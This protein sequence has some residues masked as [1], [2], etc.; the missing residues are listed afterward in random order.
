MSVLF[1][2][3]TGEKLAVESALIS[4]Q[5]ARGP[6]ELA[7]EVKDLI[8]EALAERDRDEALL[9]RVLERVRGTDQNKINEAYRFLQDYCR[10][11]I[12]IHALIRGLIQQAQ[13]AGQVISRAAALDQATHDYE[14]WQDDYAELLV[15][16]YEPVGQL[17][18]DRV[19]HA[20]RRASKES[21]WRQLFADE[22]SAP[23]TEQP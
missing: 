3:R 21:N 23:A 15:M 5:A 16:A 8:E 4:W 19:A 13:Q 14:A 9:Q 18:R 1:Q 11:S 10:R 12:H 7:E 20:V 22:D 6:A 2:I 17:L